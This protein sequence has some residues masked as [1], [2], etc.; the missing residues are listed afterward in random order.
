M[1]S[2][3]VFFQGFIPFGDLKIGILEI[4]RRRRGQSVHHHKMGYPDYK[5]RKIEECAFTH[6]FEMMRK[7][8]RLDLPRGG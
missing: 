2:F 7:P 3:L 6:S 4:L 1:K 8:V 5:N